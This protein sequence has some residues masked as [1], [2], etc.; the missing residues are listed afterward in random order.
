MK[1]PVFHNALAFI[2]R[3]QGGFVDDPDDPG[4][5]TIKGITQK[6]DNRWRQRHGLGQADVLHIDPEEGEPLEPWR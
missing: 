2:L 1:T 4:G 5:R 3:W 6:T